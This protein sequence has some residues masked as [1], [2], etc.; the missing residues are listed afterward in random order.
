MNGA[1]M[2]LSSFLLLMTN[3]HR[4]SKIVE[5]NQAKSEYIPFFPMGFL[6]DINNGKD[7]HSARFFSVFVEKCF[8]FKLGMFN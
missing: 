8:F 4:R 7:H 3:L 1:I 5:D 2:R 6:L